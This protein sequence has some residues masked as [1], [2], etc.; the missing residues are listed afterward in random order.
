MWRR[1]RSGAGVAAA[2]ARPLTAALALTAAPVLPPFLAAPAGA[3][4][5]ARLELGAPRLL[6]TGLPIPL[7]GA[8]A[9]AGERVRIETRL[10]GRWRPFAAARASAAGRFRRTVR[11]RRVRGRYLL[12]AVVAGGV[13]SKRVVVRS[14]PVLLAAVGDINLGD[15]PGALIDA[16]GPR[17]PWIATAGTLRRA[18]VA[19]GNLECAISTRGVPCRSSTTSAATRRR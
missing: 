4:E 7:R 6:A 19:F 5:P 1:S 13:P 8:G 2:L 18:D 16:F 11:P 17:Y 15:G 10:K 12:R 9:V 3:Q 14:R